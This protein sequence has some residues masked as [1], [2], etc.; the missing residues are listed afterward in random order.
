MDITNRLAGLVALVTGG[1]RGIGAEIV[2]R[3]A[4]EG[5]DVGFSY[6]T[7]KDEAERVAEQVRGL[8]RR[9]IAVAADLEDPAAA[10]AL[11]DAVA[12]EFGRLDILVNNAG[13]THW[14]A[15]AQTSVADFD[16][17]VAVDARAPFLMMQAAAGRL[18]DGGRI[19]N[20]SS[21]VTGTAVAGIGL[22]SGAKAFL[23]QVTRVAAIE[24]APRR[25]TVNAVGPGST[26]TGPFA[27]LT[28]AQR[29]EAGSAFALG[30]IGEPADTAALVAFLACEDAGFITGQ[31]IY[32][33]GGQHGPVRVRRDG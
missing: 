15:L 9:V 33:V 14:G 13:I 5:A 18:A 22:Y 31:V 2:R 3:L 16:R 17:L 25:I 32:A 8:G 24:F 11:V 21:G 27:R 4:A 23:D 6:H 29:A 30:R 20:I 7:G 26:A 10:A 19:V 1:S 28:E 12:G